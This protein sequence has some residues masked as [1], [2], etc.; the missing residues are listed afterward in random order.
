MRK[1]LILAVSSVVLSIG[2]MATAHAQ[3]APGTIVE[4][5]S[6]N[7]DFSTL[8]TAVKAAGLVETLSGKGP[9]TVFAPTDEAF[10]KL[11]AGTLDKL[12][13]DPKGDLTKIL[14]LHVIAGE[15]DAKAATAAVGTNVTTLGGPVAVAKDGD[16]LTFGGA[17]ITT[18]DIKA[19]N[20][21]IHVIDAV[22]TAPAEASADAATDTAVA[23]TAVAD[24]A[25]T[26][27]A[28]AE[29]AAADTE[30]EVPTKVATGDD[31]L[32]A[33]SRGTSGTLLL[34][35]AGAAVVGIGASSTVLV[36]AR[37]KN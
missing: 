9:F 28:V 13:A 20:G 33:S 29:T 34:L 7:P 18:T 35:L 3:A 31:G 27:T 10:K 11:P 6:A 2:A 36:K 37:R 12:L 22:V 16:K 21:I 30:A 5:A 19:S 23:D 8:V 25:A 26:D 14:T 4:V 32:A 15:V 17:T 1:K 24:T